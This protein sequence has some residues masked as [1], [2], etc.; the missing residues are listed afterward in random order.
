MLAG[1]GILG[2]A[3]VAVAQSPDSPLL[4]D[5]SWVAERLEDPALVLLHVGPEE[6]YATEHL[7]GA[8]HVKLATLSA[9]EDHDGG[10]RLSLQMPEPA[11][12]AAA[13]EALGIGDGSRVVVYYGTDWVTAST[14]VIYTL[15]W[16]GLGDRVSLL[17]GGMQR[18]KAEGHPVTTAVR[19]PD[20]GSLT[21][22]PRPERVVTA[23]WVRA[24]LDSA[25]YRIIDAR[26]PVHYDGI[27]P[28]YLHRTPVRKG[29]IPGAA[30]VPFSAIVDEALRIRP[31]EEL[32]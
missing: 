26:A 18:W 13:L 11:A 22:R 25:G 27:Q 8:V 12:L 1:A 7:P 21:P 2:A 24:R 32:R 14:R 31:V 5:P 30:N 29:H 28:T 23:D 15:D 4:V 9:P 10:S 6:D 17:D 16:I 19:T 20:R 3:A